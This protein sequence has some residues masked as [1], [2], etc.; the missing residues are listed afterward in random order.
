M[1]SIPPCFRY[2]RIVLHCVAVCCSVSQRVAV[3][4][5]VPIWDAE[6]RLLECC[7]FRCVSGTRAVC[8][9]VLQRVAACCSV[10]RCPNLG[11]WS[12]TSRMLSTPLCFRYTRSVS[13]CV[14]VCCCLQSVAV[15]CGVL[16]CVAVCCSVLQCVAV[17]QFGTLKPD[18][19]NA[20]YSAMFQVHTQCF[21]VCCSVLQCVAACC[22]VLQCVAAECCSVLQ[23]VAECCSVL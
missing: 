18:F 1:L 21:A 20:V 3:C 2:T 4:Y 9:S 6:A 19:L 15:C 23:R 16:Q 8:C 7:L 12:P 5:G 17:S 11:R 14:A 10:L 22:S 13:K